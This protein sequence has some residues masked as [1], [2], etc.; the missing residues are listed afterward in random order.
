MPAHRNPVTSLSITMARIPWQFEAYGWPLER[1]DTLTSDHVPVFM[2]EPEESPSPEEGGR[3]FACSI[4]MVSGVEWVWRG[5]VGYVER[6]AEP[7]SVVEQPCAPPPGAWRRGF[8][9]LHH[10][11][12]HLNQP[13]RALGV[14]LQKHLATTDHLHGDPGLKVWVLDAAI[15]SG[16]EC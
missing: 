5:C 9:R 12:A 14:D 15:G 2:D 3:P 4:P 8:N 6:R 7:A 1:I 13:L 16:W 10:H 11:L